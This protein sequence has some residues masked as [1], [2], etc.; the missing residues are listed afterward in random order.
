MIP[1]NI[2]T[3]FEIQSPFADGIAVTLEQPFMYVS[4]IV[5]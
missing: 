2:D 3:L 4:I 5:M 1:G